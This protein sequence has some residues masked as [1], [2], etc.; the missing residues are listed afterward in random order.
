MNRFKIAFLVLTLFAVVGVVAWS[1]T[2]QPAAP[3]APAQVPQLRLGN[4]EEEVR[5]LMGEPDDISFMRVVSGEEFPAIQYWHYELRSENA[6]VNVHLINGK[7]THID[8]TTC[9]AK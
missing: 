6:T 4:S 1:H 3:P 9:N 7:V 5:A 8:T 2:T